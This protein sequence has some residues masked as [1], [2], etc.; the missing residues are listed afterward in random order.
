[1]L[2][3]KLDEIDCALS[4]GLAVFKGRPRGTLVPWHELESA[5]GFERYTLHWPALWFRLKRDFRRQT[6]VVLWAV[7]GKG[8][9][10]LTLDE[11]LAWRSRKRHKRAA[12]QLQKD[13]VELASLPDAELSDRQRWEKSVRLDMARRRRNDIYTSLRRADRLTQPSA[14]SQPRGR[15][16]EAASAG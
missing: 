8:A 9:K 5:I 6:G 1:M 16:S 15:R 11:Q 12:R 10:L 7:N 3:P 4:R 14:V 13:Q 2:V